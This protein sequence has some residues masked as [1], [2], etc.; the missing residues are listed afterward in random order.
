MTY[1]DNEIKTKQHTASHYREH[2][3]ILC[4]HG[5]YSFPIFLKHSHY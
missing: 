1:L 4:G 5:L 3:Y 2:V